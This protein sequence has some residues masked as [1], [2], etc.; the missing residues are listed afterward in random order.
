MHKRCIPTHSQDHTY[1]YICTYST[2]QLLDILWIIFCPRISCKAHTKLTRTVLE[3]LWCVASNWA[4]TQ[5]E[6]INLKL[7][8]LLTG[9]T[10]CL[11]TYYQG[12]YSTTNFCLNNRA[13]SIL[14]LKLCPQSKTQLRSL[15]QVCGWQWVLW[16]HSECHPLQMDVP[17]LDNVV[18]GDY[19]SLRFWQKCIIHLIRIS[20]SVH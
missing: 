13:T 7:I 16:H 17:I 1:M 6:K 8:S 14:G 9:S 11:V 12:S 3:W 18:E 15:C 4:T 5:F 2:C 10:C 19:H 20:K